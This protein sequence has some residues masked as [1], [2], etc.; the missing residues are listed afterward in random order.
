VSC[1]K[2]RERES[3]RPSSFELIEF[4]VPLAYGTAQEQKK[5]RLLLLAR[6]GK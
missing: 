2:R 5:L 6:E 1:S 3:E 4:H